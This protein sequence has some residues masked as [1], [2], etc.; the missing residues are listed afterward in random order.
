MLVPFKYQRLD[1]HLSESVCAYSCRETSLHYLVMLC[2]V[3]NI[4]ILIRSLSRYLYSH[5]V[6]YA[7]VCIRSDYQII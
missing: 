6:V 7:V 5:V 1:M 2:V 3:C 4:S